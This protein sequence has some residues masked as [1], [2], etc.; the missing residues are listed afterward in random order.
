MIDY[1][2]CSKCHQAK[3]AKVDFYLCAGKWRSEC[4]MCTIKRNV[5][6]QRK[7]QA[8]KHRY[9]DDDSRRLY[10]R[11]YY[12]KNKDKFAHYR[13]EFRERHPEYYKEYFRKKKEKKNG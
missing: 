8:W 12:D 5:R 7:V 3:E 9:V 4:R 11:E 6:Y 2:I 10:M 1:K 13:E